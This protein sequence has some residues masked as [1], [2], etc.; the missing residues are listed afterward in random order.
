MALSGNAVDHALLMLACHTAGIPFAP[1]SV[2][3]SLQSQDHA[4]LKHIAE[5]LQ[6]GLVYVTDTKPFAAALAALDLSEAEVVA[7]H[8]G[9]NLAG[10]RL[11]TDLAASTPGP[12]VE[13]AVAGTG[14]DTIAKFLFTSG[15]T[16]LPK[17][18]I[19]THG[20]L[21]ANQ[22]QIDAD[23]AVPVRTA[24]GGGRLAAVESHL[25]Q[26]SQLQPGAA[27]GGHALHRSLASRC[28]R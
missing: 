7:S 19:N 1:I 9:A 6:P 28:R 14:A 26:Q 5:L 15:S 11:F 3:Y 17:G 16:G 27:P 24:A 21:A 8:N 4:K 13:R 25:R 18:V 20:M 2:A 10:T 12:G 22:Q 23:L